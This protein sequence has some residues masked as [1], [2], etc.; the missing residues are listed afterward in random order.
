MNF[1]KKL[2]YLYHLQF[3][4]RKFGYLNL[5]LADMAQEKQHAA[6]NLKW[7]EKQWLTK[8]FDNQFYHDR[9]FDNKIALDRVSAIIEIFQANPNKEQNVTLEN[10]IESG[11]SKAIKY[12]SKEE[13]EKMHKNDAARAFYR[14]GDRNISIMAAPENVYFEEE[15]LKPMVSE[16]PIYKPL[17]K[18]TSNVKNL[19]DEFTQ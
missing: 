18:Q 15:A 17:E 6:T 4:A 11:I 14:G 2:S 5:T 19:N 8:I 7:S 9:I 1:K 3:V 12:V 16:K 10:I 13:L